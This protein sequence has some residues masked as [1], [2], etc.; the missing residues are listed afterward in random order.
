MWIKPIKCKDFTRR[1]ACER[2]LRR[3]GGPSYHNASLVLSEGERERRLVQVSWLA[4]WLKEGFSSPPGHPPGKISSERNPT[5]P[6]NGSV[7]VSLLHSVT[8]WEKPVGSMIL[9]ETQRWISEHCSWG[10]WSLTLPG[11]RGLWG[12]FSWMVCI[13][14]RS[15][16]RK[17]PVCQSWGD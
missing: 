5:S 9:S 13:T 7:S 17:P 10:L 16:E 1:D 14:E 8:G 6:R 12:A 3:L 15:R 2:K 4:M 11:A